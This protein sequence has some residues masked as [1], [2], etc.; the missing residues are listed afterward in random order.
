MSRPK[1]GIVLFAV[2]LVMVFTNNAYAGGKQDCLSG[3]KEVEER[4]ANSAGIGPGG[5]KLIDTKL[6][7]AKDAS[8]DGKFKMCKNKVAEMRKILSK[9]N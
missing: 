5:Q 2:G 3:I 8:K 4:Y 7:I 6:Q 1:W 9:G